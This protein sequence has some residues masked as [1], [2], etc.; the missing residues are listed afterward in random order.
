MYSHFCFPAWF[1]SWLESLWEE[2]HNDVDSNNSQNLQA[3]GCW[4]SEKTV[5]LIHCHWTL[6]AHL[7][8]RFLHYRPG[9]EE[10]FPV[11]ADTMLNN[12]E[13]SHLL[14]MWWWQFLPQMQIGRLET[15]SSGCHIWQLRLKKIE[16]KSPLNLLCCKRIF[17]E[18]NEYWLHHMGTFPVLSSLPV[19]HSSSNPRSWVGTLM[20]VCDQF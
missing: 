11:S 6:M 15:E 5:C 18:T 4:S 8:L 19:S 2:Y 3:A 20:T 14:D 7:P 13:Y 9:A 10:I 12:C 17:T 1:M 16:N